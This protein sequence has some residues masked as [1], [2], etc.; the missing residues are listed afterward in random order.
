MPDGSPIKG[1][2]GMI[3]IGSV[4]IET[5]SSIS[6]W[7]P[8]VAHWTGSD[9]GI[10]SVHIDVSTIIDIDVGISPAIAID[11]HP[12][13]GIVVGIPISGAILGITS[14]VPGTCDI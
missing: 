4:T 11:I 9:H 13:V 6:V 2:V 8:G 3:V 5:V 12:I 14:P 7:R 1:R 10:S